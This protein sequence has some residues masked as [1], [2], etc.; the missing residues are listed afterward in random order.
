[1]NGALKVTAAEANRHPISVF[2]LI[3]SRQE[4][5]K[6]GVSLCFQESRPMSGVKVFTPLSRTHVASKMSSK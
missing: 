4:N 3:F 2:F 6:T 1:M 5:K